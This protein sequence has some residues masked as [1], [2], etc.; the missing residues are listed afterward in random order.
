MMIVWPDQWYHTSGD[1]ID[2]VDPTQMR[3][4]AVIGAAA[5]YTVASADDN[6]AV[7]LAGEIASNGTRR[8]GHQL[9]IAQEFL[10]GA[11]PENFQDQY[12]LARAHIVGTVMAETE[13]LES[14]LQL[15]QIDDYVEEMQEAIEAVGEAHLQAL[16]AHMNAA[17]GRLGV[18]PVRLRE[19]DL[20]E[21][22]KG[23]IP[24][25][26]A[27]V[28]RDGYTGWRAHLQEVPADVRAQYP[29]Q[30]LN[31]SELQLLIDGRHT[32]LDIAVMISAQNQTLTDIQ[33]VLNYLE[34][35]K[36]A[37]LVEM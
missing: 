3:R 34:V 29:Y 8:L 36:A 1:R 11:T 30:G 14:V 18:S 19:T 2:K 26:T 7:K 33:A 28:K 37:G 25:Q 12:K 15:G 31:T 13:T 24:R 27:L 10:N 23:V 9:V 35:L 6:M 4:I 32:A 17:A 21:Q 22:A 16:E 5:A 20:E